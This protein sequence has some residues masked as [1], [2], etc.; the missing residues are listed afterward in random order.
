MPPPPITQAEQD[1]REQDRDCAKRLLP[2]P[3]MGY[4]LVV[5]AIVVV[6]VGARIILKKIKPL[7]Y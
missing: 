4:A 2:H 7:Q 5:C 3:H 6:V 1:R